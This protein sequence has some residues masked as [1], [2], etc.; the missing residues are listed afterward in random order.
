MDSEQAD[1]LFSE[2]ETI[3]VIDNPTFFSPRKQIVSCERCKPSKAET[4]LEMILDGINGSDPTCTSYF[5]G[6]ELLCQ[7][8]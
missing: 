2:T 7:D 1:G 3:L 5:I 8:A 6:T 4:S